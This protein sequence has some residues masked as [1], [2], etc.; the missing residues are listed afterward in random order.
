MMQKVHC[1]L[2]TISGA[3]PTTRPLPTNKIE[4]DSQDEDKCRPRRRRYLKFCLLLAVGFTSAS[5]ISK[6]VPTYVNPRP[7]GVEV[8]ANDIRPI[9]GRTL[10][11]TSVKN[12][13]IKMGLYKYSNPCEWKFDQKRE[14][15][16]VFNQS[17]Y[18]A[19]DPYFGKLANNHSGIELNQSETGAVRNIMVSLQKANFEWASGTIRI[20][21]QAKIEASS[22]SQTILEAVAL[23]KEDNVRHLADNRVR[24]LW[25]TKELCDTESEWLGIAFHYGF[26]KIIQ[27]IKQ[28]IINNH[29]ALIQDKA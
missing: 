13:S 28:E 6:P 21:F 16:S 17:V 10:L 24:M 3:G 22:G 27:E 4:T 15:G 14:F 1:H 12:V 23:A 7:V 25:S 11:S 8:S 20:N 29:S 5:C 26:E 9:P 2:Q 19:L 18:N